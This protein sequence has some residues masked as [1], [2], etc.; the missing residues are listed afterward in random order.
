M[1][2][3]LWFVGLFPVSVFFLAGC[4]GGQSALNPDARESNYIFDLWSLFCVVLTIIYC[5]VLLLL[6][7]ALARR[8][9]SE[10]TQP[11]LNPDARQERRMGIAVG[12]AV[13]VTTICLFVF[14]IADF[15]AG[16]TIHS[17]TDP[18]PLRLKIRGHQWWWEV[19]YDHETASN[20]VTT[21]NEIHV[22]IGKSVEFDLE[23]VDVIHSFWAPNF[24]GKKDLVPGHP[25]K[26]W[27]R[28]DQPGVFTGQCAEYCGAQHAH[29]RFVIVAD[30]PGQFALWYASQQ[31]PAPQPSSDLER[32]GQ[33]I[34][35]ST[36]C[37]MCH[38][39]QGTTARATIGPNLTHLAGRHSLAAGTVTNNLGHLAGW[40]IDPQK[41]KPGVLMPQHNL[42][43]Q[44]LRAL[45]AY[46]ESLK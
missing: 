16:R 7:I 25:T 26:L 34:F 42:S 29:M 9:K 18:H 20:M 4:S 46:L 33:E 31:Q 5:L 11:I 3:A 13:V 22:P 32:R 21:A 27:F 38:T 19:Q 40:I 28:A 8:G 39:I 14:L 10:D 45:L 23:S 2:R 30:E 41:I 1:K 44:D 37:I 36:T 24:N 17:A 12:S 6:T 15:A 35:L 43:P